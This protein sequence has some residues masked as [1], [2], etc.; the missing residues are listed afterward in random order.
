MRNVM[1]SQAGR[2]RT[3][4]STKPTRRSF[5]GEYK[6]RILSEAEAC[7]GQ[8]GEIGALLRREGLY[9][10]LLDKWRNQAERAKLAALEPKKRGP[11][12]R[13]ADARDRTIAEQA[14]I[15]EKLSKRVERAEALVEIQKK[16]SEILG[17]ALPKIEDVS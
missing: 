16:V 7:A 6:A 13:E 4:V 2:P 11:T 15:I 17:I 5:T 12:P 10:S 9:W 8:S 1:S 3:E 14:R